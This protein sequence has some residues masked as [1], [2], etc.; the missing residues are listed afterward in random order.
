MDKTITPIRCWFLIAINIIIS[1]DGKTLNDMYE[2]NRV[3]EQQQPNSQK[4]TTN[5]LFSLSI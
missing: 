3:S 4:L 5:C 2:N 1:T